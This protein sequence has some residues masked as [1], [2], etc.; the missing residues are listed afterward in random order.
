[1]AKTKA[2]QAKDGALSKFNL[3]KII[4][5]RYQTPV[6][7][8]LIFLLFLIYFSPMYFGGKTF[9][10]GDIITSKSLGSAITADKEGYTL[11]N[12]YIFCGMPAYGIGVGF[13][14]FNLIYVASTAVRK[15]FTAPFAVEYATWTFFLLLLSFTSY[16]LTKH[17]T[18]NRMISLFS[19]LA[20]TFS[21]GIIVFLFIGHVTKLTSLCMHPLIFLILLKFQ[22]K[23][24]ILDA[25]VL[26]A[27]LQIFFQGWHVQIIFY[28]LFAVGIYFVYYFVR[29]V[30][31]KDSAFTKQ[32]LKSLGVFVIAAV[33]ALLIQLD[34]FTQI[35]A[36]NPYSTRGTQSIVE[37][38]AGAQAQPGSSMF[39]EYA[40][41]WSFSP[42]EVATFL[43][44]SFYGFGN[45]TYNGPL[46]NNQDYR[47]N[48]YFGQMDF[49]DV[50][51]Y[52]GVIVFLLGL[53]GIFTK[54]K[55]PFV[56]FLT[57][58]SAI[59]LLI[60]F[61]S[62]FSFFY[63]L[64][65][66]YFPFFNRFRVPSMILVLVQMSFPVL[67]AF[68]LARIV[69]LRNEN[70][71]KARAA[72]KYIAFALSGILLLTLFLSSP[73]RDW[74]SQ[75]MIDAAR[76]QQQAEYFKQ[77]SEYAADMFMGDL[78]LAFALSAATFWLAW[79]YIN[80]RL[81]R[82]LMLLL[83][84]ALALFDLWRIDMRG[85]EYVQNQD[86]SYMFNT[87]DYVS[88]IKSQNDKAPFRI[89]NIKQDGSIGSIG[90]NSNYHVYFL[91]EDLY[92]YSG[93]K[94]RA[95]QDIMDVVGTPANP[96]LWRML[97]VKYI[98]TERPIAYPGLKEIFR[99]QQ[100]VVYE[101][102]PALPR[103]YFVDSVMN[104]KSMAGLNM[105]KNN[106]FDPKQKAFVEGA[107]TLKVDRPD[108]SVYAHITNYSEEHITISAKASGNNF[109]FLG[110]TYYPNGW[111]ALID[112]KETQIYRAN[113]GFRG[114]MVPA[115]VHK[116][117]FIFA[118]E[119]FYIS[120]K[121]ALVLSSLVLGALI[122]GLFLEFRKR[123]SE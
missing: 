97:N 36:Y 49:V 13:K 91:L 55:N 18:Q 15:V 35:Y 94:P 111:K 52:M 72:V 109:L 73:L 121:I 74:F 82:D 65:Y 14:W 110:D 122:F 120:Q 62:T 93:I 77:L 33:I 88:A 26:T 112:G 53:Y 69:E 23:I 114:I 102:T 92:G 86:I 96:T 56:Q 30:S 119:S 4:P 7:L 107:G 19:A 123:K 71:V 76:S 1:M 16:F 60:S 87:P 90:Q 59:S 28:T 9:Q 108:T 106:M 5:E 80:A 95:Y 37:N 29:S 10:S 63:D 99:S 17:L 43:V 64:M 46:S 39:Y 75:R 51:M 31:R 66:N 113:H 21:T 3:D 25:A 42:G 47:V 41:R 79:A 118:P 22:K 100:S 98:I 50:A 54:W 45:S 20:T 84:T 103:A 67:A 89:L 24:R 12:P 32:L 57:I 61:G 104:L 83:V 8:G 44:P 78:F 2:R 116:V 115:G 48:T 58:L 68:G 40:T 101:F 6:L 38:E 117:E 85:G 34:N 105:I 11:W 81:G 70:D 27:A